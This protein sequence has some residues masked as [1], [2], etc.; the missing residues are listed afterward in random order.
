MGTVVRGK[1]QLAS[2]ATFVL[3]LL[4]ATLVVPFMQIYLA[5]ILVAGVAGALLPKPVSAVCLGVYGAVLTCV[6]FA[7]YP[8]LP[9][10]QIFILPGILTGVAMISVIL[11]GLL[12]GLGRVVHAR[13]AGPL[14]GSVIQP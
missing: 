2:G 11:G 12:A 10:S 7:R 1:A 9:I 6:V 8:H 4:G 3:A 14:V 5:L 13:K